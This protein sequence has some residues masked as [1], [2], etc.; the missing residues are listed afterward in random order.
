MAWVLV[1][2]VSLCIA[3]AS[4]LVGTLTE[5]V[6]PATELEAATAAA[7]TADA[8]RELV[9]YGG[10]T[11]EVEVGRVRATPLPVEDAGDGEYLVNVPG[12]D[13]PVYLSEPYA[14]VYFDPV[15]M[16]TAHALIMTD[17]AFNLRTGDETYDRVMP[18][19]LYPDGGWDAVFYKGAVAFEPVPVGSGETITL[20]VPYF[21]DPGRPTAVVLA[22]SEVEFPYSAFYPPGVLNTGQIKNERE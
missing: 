15:A 4:V 6:E 9:F 7:R 11:G 10:L 18:R 13:R 19:P 16:S 2:A 12:T 20:D 1:F 3:V 14:V 22:A 5:P 21:V 17:S 8:S